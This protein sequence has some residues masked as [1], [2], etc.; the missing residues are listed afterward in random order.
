MIFRNRRE[1]VLQKVH[2]G[3]TT[4]QLSVIIAAFLRRDIEDFW[5]LNSDALGKGVFFD[6][7]FFN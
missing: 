2:N 1:E 3:V 5:E 7:Y 4:G 6:V